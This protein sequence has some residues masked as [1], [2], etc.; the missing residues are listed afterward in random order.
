MLQGVLYGVGGGLVYA[1][2]LIWV[3][4]SS[5]SRGCRLLHAVIDLQLSEW[6]VQRRGLAW[7]IIFGGSGVGG[8]VFPI[9]INFLLGRVGG[10]RW[11][12]RIW[13]AFIA[14]LG[15]VALYFSRPRLPVAPVSRTGQ[16]QVAPVNWAC[17]LVH[18]IF[19]AHYSADRNI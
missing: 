9:I 18:G 12:L 1:P 3:S 8:T 6:F 15:N 7:G 19:L 4:L 14:V 10:F 17:V 5:T 2:V 16:A 11:T 13:A